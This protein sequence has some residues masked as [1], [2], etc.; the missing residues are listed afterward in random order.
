MATDGAGTA[1]ATVQ[2]PITVGQ[3]TAIKFGNITNVATATCVMTPGNDTPLGTSCAGG[4]TT[5]GVFAISSEA[6][7]L[8]ITLSITTP[9]KGDVTFAPIW[10]NGDADFAAGA[11]GT[12][13][14]PG[15]SFDINLGGTLTNGASPVSGAQSWDYT[16][17]VTYQ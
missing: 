10:S 1:S 17:A 8:D 7:T 14:A 9:V 16:V 13:A 3:T 5:A 15:G 6:A 2:A 11:T 4:T 12:M